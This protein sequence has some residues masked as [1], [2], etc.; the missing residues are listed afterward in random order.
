METPQQSIKTAEDLA[1]IKSLLAGITEK[2]RP[3]EQI[4][5]DLEVMRTRYDEY[6]KDID[7]LK[8]KISGNGS[9]G[10]EKRFE[11]VESRMNDF[12]WLIGIIVVAAIGDIVTRIFLP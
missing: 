4:K 1:V 6:C 8:K 3:I 12:L 2:V 11:K 7:D 10:L 9:P 5:T